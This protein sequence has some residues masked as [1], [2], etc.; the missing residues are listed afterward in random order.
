[1]H[2]HAHRHSGQVDASEIGL[3][4]QI[5]SVCVF[6][7]YTAAV[8]QFIQGQRFMGSVNHYIM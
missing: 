7:A 3:L 1:M 8:K 4:R 5:I 6:D 2:E